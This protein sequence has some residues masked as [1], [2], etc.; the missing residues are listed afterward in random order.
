MNKFS[1]KN[2]LHVVEQLTEE[3][4]E[5]SEGNTGKFSIDTTET[6]D[7][8]ICKPSTSNL[9]SVS[10]TSLDRASQSSGTTI[11][12]QIHQ[13]LPFS[14]ESLATPTLNHVAFTAMNLNCS[15]RS[16]TPESRTPQSPLSVDSQSSHTK[17]PYS[18]SLFP[19]GLKNRNGIVFIL[20]YDFVILNV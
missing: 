3:Q 12:Q 19:T 15:E 4:E 6:T 11:S 9:S 13:P 2:I 5:D 14:A 16:S 7:N 20:I 8:I 1:A 18:L 17:I 10:Q